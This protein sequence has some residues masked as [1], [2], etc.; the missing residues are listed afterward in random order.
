MALTTTQCYWMRSTVLTTITSL[1]YSVPTLQSY[2][3]DVIL[4]I[5]MP[6][7]TAVSLIIAI[8]YYHAL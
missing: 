2:I 5:M 7:C 3:V 8:V 6:L 4:T 1:S